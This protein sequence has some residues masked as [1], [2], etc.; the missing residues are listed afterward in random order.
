MPLK[1]VLVSPSGTIERD[2]HLPT[3]DI[4]KWA[5]VISRLHKQGIRVAVWSNRKWT[6]NNSTPLHEYL[7]AKAGCLV[8][9]VG[10]ATS[11]SPYRQMAGSVDPILAQFN[12]QRH[13]TILI[14]ARDEDL[15]AGVNN[16]LFLLRPSWYGGNLEYGFE[17]KSISELER[18]CSLFGTRQHPFYWNVSDP[19]AD[20]QVSALG[21]FSTYIEQYASFSEDARRAAKFDAGT[22]EFWHQLIVSTLYFSGIM[23]KVDYI[24]VY[25]SHTSGAKSKAFYDDLS[26]LGKCFGKTFFPDLLLR[27]SDAPKSSKSRAA[28]RLFSNQVNSIK[29]NRYPAKYGGKP[30]KTALSLA[31]KTILVI[32]DICTSGRSIDC[33]RSYLGAAGASSILFAWLKTINT[34][35]LSMTPTPGL[36]PYQQNILTAEPAHRAY[37]YSQHIVD[38]QAPAEIETLLE[39][40]KKWVA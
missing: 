19:H 28:D 6:V 24:T 8:S 37:G 2:G 14:G 30:R 7:G 12:V 3:E 36:S 31:G 4:N 11:N 25:P 39:A 21:P 29:L 10:H 33:A 40:Y 35:F 32:D 20:L 1:L 5:E 17:L 13:E 15:R 26:L 38:A 18:F 27:H 23:H 9:A 16:K 22:L 34:D